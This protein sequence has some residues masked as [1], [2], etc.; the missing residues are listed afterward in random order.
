MRII[1]QH[2][3]LSECTKAN[4]V[5]TVPLILGK[6]C[7]V[8]GVYGGFGF[9]KPSIHKK[10]GSVLRVQNKTRDEFWTI[11]EHVSLDPYFG[12]VAVSFDRKESEEQDLATIIL[13]LKEV[14][15][16][17]GICYKK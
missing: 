11:N 6:Y 7:V 13:K 17:D 4:R 9:I 15:I 12:F 14:G 2:E 10:R 16:E 5:L 8:S 1:E 3:I